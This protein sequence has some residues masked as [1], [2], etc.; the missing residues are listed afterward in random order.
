MRFYVFKVIHPSVSYGGVLRIEGNTLNDAT[1]ELSSRLNI[2]ERLLVFQRVADINY[3]SNIEQMWYDASIS[4]VR[5]SIDNYR[6]HTQSYAPMQGVY[7]GD[8]FVS[9]SDLLNYSI[10]IDVAKHNINISCQG[11]TSR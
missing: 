11:T 2:E 5:N 4:Y 1:K 8:A 6:L 7:I 10:A 9:A 3:C